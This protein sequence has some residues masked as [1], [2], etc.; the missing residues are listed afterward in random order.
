MSARGLR[1][2]EIAQECVLS[3]DTVNSTI[4]K[5]RQRIGAKTVAQAVILA[6]ARE[7]LGLTHTG[8]CFV[9]EKEI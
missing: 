1:P 2:G 7:E 6:I 4:T 5:A 3:K 9:A 8:E